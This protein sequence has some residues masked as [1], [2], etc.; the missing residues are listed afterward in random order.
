MEFFGFLEN[1][2]ER[3]EHSFSGLVYFYQNKQKL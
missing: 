1:L 3:S 2:F